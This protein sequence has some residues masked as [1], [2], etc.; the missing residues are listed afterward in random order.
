MITPT[1][2]LLGVGKSGF[3]AQS[4]F[5]FPQ[6][7]WNRQQYGPGRRTTAELDLIITQ[8]DKSEGLSRDSGGQ[9]MLGISDESKRI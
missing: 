5:R 9:T 7:V 2:V 4:V 3:L 6:T 8:L 1:S